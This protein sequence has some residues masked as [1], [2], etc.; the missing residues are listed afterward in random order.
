MKKVASRRMNLLQQSLLP[1]PMNKRSIIPLKRSLPMHKVILERASKK[2][3]ISQVQLPLPVL[4]VSLQISFIL[5]PLLIDRVEIRIIEPALNR[6]R[7]VIKDRP[8]P[9][10]LVVLPLSLVCDLPVGIVECPESLHFVVLPLPSV[11]AALLIDK[12]SLT[13]THAVL[14]ETFVS[15]P[16]VE[17]LHDVTVFLNWNF[18]LFL[19]IYK[20]YCEVLT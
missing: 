15:G 8:H 13:V 4:R 14:L 17:L 1:D 12:L 9:V 2:L 5:H 20:A 19:I 10:E 18:G 7:I 11:P 16:N 6:H 3:P